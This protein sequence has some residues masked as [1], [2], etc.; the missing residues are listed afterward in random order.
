MPAYAD[1]NRT[2]RP[3]ER[4]FALAAVV[5]VQAALGF[6]LLN[7][8]RVPIART[9]DVVERLIE[10]AIP[11]PPPTPPPIVH[12]KAAH[13][14]SSAPK[15]APKPLGGSPGRKPAHAPPS[16]TPAVAVRP[17]AAPSGGGAGTGPALGSGTGGGTGGRGYG[18]GEGGSD[19]EQIAG[20]IF[21]SDY[22]SH[23]GY[24]GNRRVSVSFTVQANGRV[25]GCRV[26]RSSGIAE[27]DALTCR[28][29][30]QRFRFRPGTD[31]YGRPI[32]DEADLDQDW[33]AP[34]L[35]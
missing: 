16:V 6:A 33:I 13:R 1:R 12:R 28:L 15:A 35:R 31:R 8:L 17:S 20:E 2:V 34:R 5:L 9:V 24:A 3:R 11:P 29:I 4:V 10:I 23:L 25:T 26:T 32:P 21:P 19:L 30:E 14:A 27:L 18:A 7:G 22:P